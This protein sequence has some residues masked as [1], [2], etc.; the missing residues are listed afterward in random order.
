MS[1]SVA[2]TAPKRRGGRWPLVIAAC[3][4]VGGAGCLLQLTYGG[5]GDDPVAVTKPAQPTST[6]VV[7]APRG[8]STEARAEQVGESVPPAQL[9]IPA[10]DV[11]TPLV[12]LG[13]KKDKTVEVPVNPSLAGWYGLGPAPGDRGSAVILG[14]VDSVNGPA[15]FADLQHL[16]AGDRVTVRSADGSLDR[17]EVTSVVTYPNAGFPARKVYTP[18]GHRALNLVTCGGLYD[19]DRGGYQSNVVV[20]TRWTGTVA[21]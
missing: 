20:Y 10:I 6:V 19:S 1:P 12:S 16:D 15:V 2:P 17:F 5:G 21:A 14:H 9:S 13:V 3:L 4:A 18:Q 8:A 7:P 11:S